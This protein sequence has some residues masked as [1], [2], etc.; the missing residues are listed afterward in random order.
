MLNEKDPAAA[1]LI[2]PNNFKRV[3]RALEMHEEGVS[4]ANQV[5]N[6]RSLPEA[7]PSIRFFLEVDPFILAERINARVDM[8]REEG[9]V[10]EVEALMARGFE[11]ALTAPKAI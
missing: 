1:K 8:M 2:H 11:E 10:E 4:Y 5:K 6:I 9:L 7:I 3:I